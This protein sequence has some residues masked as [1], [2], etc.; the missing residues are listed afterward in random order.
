MNELTE[1]MNDLD[2]ITLELLLNKT[3]YS[4]YLSVTNPEKLE[5]QQKFFKKIEKYK[6][7][8]QNLLNDFLEDP[9]KLINNELNES[10]QEFSRTCI[11][12]LENT[13]DFR[14]EPSKC[15]YNEDDDDMLF[16]EKRMENNEISADSLDKIS[17][18]FR[19]LPKKCK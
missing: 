5:E 7:G 10:F 11:K 8:I 9:K 3:Q 6:I 17:K 2:K 13:D 16:D 14:E 15:H 19:T 1:K 4:R 18:A 12:Y